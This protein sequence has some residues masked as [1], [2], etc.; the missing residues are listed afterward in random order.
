MKNPINVKNRLQMHDPINVKKVN[1]TIFI[2]AIPAGM[3]I[4]S[5][6]PGAILPRNIA[7]S[8]CLTNHVSVFLISD[9]EIK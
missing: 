4:H 7:N 6:I 8:P 9:S 3:E 1:L 5:R 2:S